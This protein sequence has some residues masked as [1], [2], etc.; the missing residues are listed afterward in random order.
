MSMT[1]I[2]T[3]EQREQH[4]LYN[5]PLFTVFEDEHEMNGASQQHSYSALLV[6]PI[7]ATT[8]N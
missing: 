5:V 2:V 4:R 6:H 7:P 1:E 8:G 3:V